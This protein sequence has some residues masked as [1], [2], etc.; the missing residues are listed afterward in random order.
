MA[1]VT[2]TRGDTARQFKDTLKNSDGSVIDLTDCKV[3]FLLKEKETRAVVRQ[4][5][6]ILDEA[7]GTVEYWPEAEDVAVAGKY[8]QEW[9]IEY[10]DGKILSVPTKPKNTVNIVEDLG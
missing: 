3:Y 5:A 10:Q 8:W 1:T 2:L 4:E 9:E 6:D 7:A